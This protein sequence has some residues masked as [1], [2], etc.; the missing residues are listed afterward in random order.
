VLFF[1]RRLGAAFLAFAIAISV[2]RVLLAMHYPSDVVAGALTGA[3]AAIAVCTVARPLIV[4]LTALA[5]RITDPL[6]RRIWQLG[7]RL[8]AD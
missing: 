8:A 2:S 5:A 4:R 6:L 3:V 1:N 7:A